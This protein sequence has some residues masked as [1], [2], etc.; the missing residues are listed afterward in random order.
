MDEYLV[1]YCHVQ[2]GEK[3][4]KCSKDQLPN[5]VERLRGISERHYVKVYK[6]VEGY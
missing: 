1:A 6:L 5:V 3:H 2:Y 4:Q